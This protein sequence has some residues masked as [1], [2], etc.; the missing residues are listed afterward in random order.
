MQKPSN[1]SS[2]SLESIQ[3]MTLGRLLDRALKLLPGVFMKFLPFYIVLCVL[4]V[5]Q[6]VAEGSG[7]MG[8][9]GVAALVQ[10]V[11][12]FP[13]F[14]GVIFMASDKW[15][16]KESTGLQC[17]RRMNLGLVLRSIWLGIRVTVV[18][19]LG[20]ILLVIPGVV[21][22]VNRILAFYV[23]LI[24]NASVNDSLTKSKAL[25]TSETWYKMS[26]P[27]MRFTGMTILFMVVGGFAAVLLGVASVVEGEVFGVFSLV[28][29]AVITL[30]SQLVTAFTYI[31]YVGFYYD[32]RVRYE[33]S[34][35]MSGLESLAEER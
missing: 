3:P 33:G 6:Q 28:I 35:V 25:M 17:I 19:M 11:V 22:A 23:L 29:F 30:V 24:E 34:D 14:F 31:C 20:L 7:N 13:L 8:L 16:G 1:P 2:A 18:T 32:L 27:I 5:I 26:S 9:V 12:G 10:I 21:Y 15:L 4:G